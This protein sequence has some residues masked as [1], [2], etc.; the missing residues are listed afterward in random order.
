MSVEIPEFIKAFISKEC[1]TFAKTMPQWP[2][3]YLVRAKCD[4]DTFSKFVSFIYTN[5]YVRA[6]HDR[7]FTY[8]DIDDYS[9]WTTGNPVDQTTIIN[10]AK[11]KY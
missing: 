7:E 3:W 4:D 11:A 8:L 1:W 2:H 9:Y 10:R 6:W 5:G